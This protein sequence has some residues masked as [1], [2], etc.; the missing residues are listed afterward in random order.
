MRTRIVIGTGAW[1]LG[2]AAATAGG[3]L[4]VSE[5]GE[6]ISAS[7]AGQQSSA[8]A[9]EQAQASQAAA[10]PSSPPASRSQSGTSGQNGAGG[11]GTGGSGRTASTSGTVLSSSGGTVV[12]Q[13]A[14]TGAFLLSWSPQQGFTASSVARGPATTA[15]VVFAG[16]GSTVTMAV[17]CASGVPAAA[18]TV[19]SAAAPPAP[20]PSATGDDNGGGGGNSGPGGG[21]GGGGG[22]DD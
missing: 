8:A 10:L 22:G 18:T 19:A 16:T 13:C 12:A 15:R 6:G 3:L 5:L 17:S 14:A 9:A 11:A 2:A 4:V 20:A 1:L 7:P 21:G